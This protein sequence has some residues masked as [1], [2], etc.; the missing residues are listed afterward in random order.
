MSEPQTPPAALPFPDNHRPGCLMRSSTAEYERTGRMP[1]CSCGADQTPPAVSPEPDVKAPIDTEPRCA[2][3]G[4]PLAES[5][6]EGCVIGN[7]S[8]RPWPPR[9]YD[10]ERADREYGH[11]V[12]DKQLPLPAVQL[13]NERLHEQVAALEA[14]LRALEEVELKMQLWLIDNK[15]HYHEDDVEDVIAGWLQSLKGASR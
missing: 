12:S 9:F 7:C 8:Q 3:C 4:W 6:E 11:S 2:I 1:E 10:P 14:R 13:E 15:G 5:V